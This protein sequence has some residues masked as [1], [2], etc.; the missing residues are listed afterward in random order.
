M[1]NRMNPMSSVPEGEY[2]LLF[3]KSGYTT[4]PLRCEVAR[5][6]PSFRLNQ[7]WVNYAG[8]SVFDAGGTPADLLGWLPLPNYDPEA[9]TDPAV[10]DPTQWRCGCGYMN[11]QLRTLCRSCQAHKEE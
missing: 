11:H 6:V 8:D 7:P 2:V 9:E 5:C 3:I 4:T 1:T 10:I